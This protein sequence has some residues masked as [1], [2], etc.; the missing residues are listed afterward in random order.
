MQYGGR[1]GPAFAAF[2][3]EQNMR[4]ANNTINE[5]GEEYIIH[6]DTLGI[7]NGCI[8]LLIQEPYYPEFAY[9][10]TYD[11]QAINK[12]LYQQALDNFNR[13]E[14][15]CRALILECQRL[16]TEGDPDATG[17]NYTVNQACSAANVYCGNEVESQ[18]INESGR[19]YYDI[20]S[21]DPTPF[22]P[23]YYL[24][25][26]SQHYVQGALGVPINYTQSTNGVYEAFNSI[27][28][29]ARTDIRGGQIQDL[30]YL[31]DNG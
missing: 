6:L 26:L 7:V 15:G 11:I 24:G 30:A 28:D 12:T 23:N 9:N 13:P 4:I 19:N 16:A 14:T 10:N 17:N 27:G 5:N 8:D 29:Y 21:I 22:P 18:Y 3:E 2:F 20:A 1:Y 25:Y 31:L